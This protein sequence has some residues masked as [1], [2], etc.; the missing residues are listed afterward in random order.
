MPPGSL[1]NP[2]PPGL[3]W[4]EH[5][6]LEHWV[7]QN[8]G[9]VRRKPRPPRSSTEDLKNGFYQGVKHVTREQ[10]CLVSAHSAEGTA[11]RF[12]SGKAAVT[13]KSI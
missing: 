1:Q 11:Y 7:R 10:K 3:L 5:D 6:S 2:W 4:A 8:N 12:S 13:H 9:K